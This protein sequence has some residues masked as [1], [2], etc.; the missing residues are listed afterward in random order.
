VRY[1]LELGRP[2]SVDFNLFA[3]WTDTWD[4]MPA[5]GSSAVKCAGFYGVDCGLPTPTWRH[6]LRTT[7]TTPWD[8]ALTLSWNHISAVKLGTEDDPATGPATDV[9]LPAFDYIDLAATCRLLDRY[10]VRGGVSNVT[11]K[12][13]P[14]IGRSS[15]PFRVGSGN[16]FPTV[17]NSLGRYLFLGLTV[18]FGTGGGR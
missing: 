10:T 16:T 4:L 17:Y 9:R 1:R 7:W 18:D 8:L 12:D 13:P 2:G 3:T 5:A 15:L 6:T 11:D 14:L